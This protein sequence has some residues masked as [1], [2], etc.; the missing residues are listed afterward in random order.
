MFGSSRLDLISNWNERLDRAHFRVSGLAIECMVTERHLRRYFQAKFGCS[1]HAWITV[2]RLQKVRSLLLEGRPVKE[3]AA[4]AGFEHPSNFSRHFKR[5]H[6]CNP[7]Y[8]A[9]DPRI[10]DVRF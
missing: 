3:V 6:N 7:S 4:V 8:Y 2:M 10:M 9:C 5:Y 1:P